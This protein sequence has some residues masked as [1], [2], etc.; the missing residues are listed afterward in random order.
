METQTIEIDLNSYPKTSEQ[1]WAWLEHDWNNILKI[2]KK[3][4]KDKTVIKEIV[5]CKES[6]DAKLGPLL[7]A[8]WD[9]IPESEHLKD[10]PGWH[11]FG[12]LVSELD[13]LE[14][15]IS[16]MELFKQRHHHFV[17]MEA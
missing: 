13:L 6:Q 9:T 7:E 14:R 17:N 11:V 16:T 12:E 15:E 8:C 3:H 5:T 10:I 2:V 4:T 1:W